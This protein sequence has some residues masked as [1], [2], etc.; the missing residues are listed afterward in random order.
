MADPSDAIVVHRTIAAPPE[1]IFRA[2]TSGDELARWMSPVGHAEVEV[3][4]RIG[5]VLRVTMIGEGL[6][7]EHIG[8]FLELD[9]PHRLAFTWRSV[10][11]GDVATQVAVH[12][13][14]AAG[15]T[16]TDVILHH[17]LLPEAARSSHA[18]GWGAMLDRLSAIAAT[19]HEKA[20]HGA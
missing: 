5:G 6:R 4:P 20:P 10:H 12:L 3:E 14:P 18:G 19:N 2:F 9:P 15:G 7:I 8:E 11:T 16:A 1:R 17:E 13:H